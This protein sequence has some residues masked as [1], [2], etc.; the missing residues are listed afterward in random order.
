[1]HKIFAVA[2]REYNAAVRTKAF[3]IS[4]F[5]MPLLMGGSVL[6]QVIKSISKRSG[7]RFPLRA[8]CELTLARNCCLLRADARHTFLRVE[9]T[10]PEC[11]RLGQTK[12]ARVSKPQLIS[13][14]RS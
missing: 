12:H 1:M 8:H 13:R 2:R 3:L 11:P 9:L 7:L 4:L 6:M 14:I 10:P 5:L